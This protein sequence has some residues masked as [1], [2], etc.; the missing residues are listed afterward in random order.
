MRLITVSKLH[1][2]KISGPGSVPAG[3]ILAIA[4]NT[5]IG[6]LCP[7]SRNCNC[8]DETMLSSLVQIAP[9]Y[10]FR[11]EG[12]LTVPRVRL[13]RLSVTDR[14]NFRCRYCLP[15]EGVPRL[16]HD[17]LLPFEELLHLTAWLVNHAGIERVRLTGGEPLMRRGIENLVAGLVKIPGIREVALTTNGSL[18]QN[19][20]RALKRA[21]LKRVN[22]SLDSLDAAGFAEV[23]R[24]GNLDSTLAGIAAAC[25][26]ELKPIK[27]NTVLRRSTWKHEVPSL[28]D[29]AA[30]SGFE[31]R[32]I[33]LMRTG[34]E[35][36]WC[37]GEFVSVDEVIG[38]LMPH[39]VPLECMPAGSSRRT[40]LNWRGAPVVV[41]WITPRSHPFCSSCDRLRMDARGH[42]RRCLMDPA[43]L[44]LASVLCTEP[45]L[46]A[47]QI[48][49][50]YM[51]RK[52]APRAMDSSM[53][54][55]Q[56]GG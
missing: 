28:L 11:Q 17:D 18:L 24:G 38:T 19:Q 20:A 40:M 54:M 35:R 45:P 34:T 33:E 42:I 51:A 15:A 30:Q 29:Y 50:N 32:F 12:T 52:V 36:H 55:S 14:C 27:L 10:S 37:E 5:T 13:L 41:G 16:K 8:D 49:K 39:I 23:T 53:A 56:I 44:D 3:R 4:G 6:H 9:D 22:I 21:G 43:Q 31:I 2:Q 1:G 47:T 25:E 7:P 48:F 26:A 46:A